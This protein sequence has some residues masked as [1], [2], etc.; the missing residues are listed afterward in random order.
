[1]RELLSVW[2]DTRMVVMVAVTSA[3]Y[4]AVL[5]PMKVIM[6]LVPGFT[7]VRPANVLPVFFSFLFGPVAA[8]GAAFGNVVGDMFGTFGPGSFFG[9]FGNFLYGLIPYRVWRFWARRVFRWQGHR[10]ESPQFWERGGGRDGRFGVRDFLL[11]AAACIPACA[12]CGLVIGWGVDLLGFVQFG[13]L[14]NVIFLNNVVMAIILGPPLISSLGR[15]VRAW[16]MTYGGSSEK[17]A[18][19][20]ARGILGT[21]LVIG[22]AGGGFIA[23]NLMAPDPGIATSGIPFLSVRLLPFVLTSGAGALLL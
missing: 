23:G 6:P 5:I 18:P 10:S 15:R 14:A 4:A 9:F 12:A 3:L 7:E 21:A 13:V 22:G 2:R 20:L 19:S 1:M 11:Y 8:W 17:S 16:G